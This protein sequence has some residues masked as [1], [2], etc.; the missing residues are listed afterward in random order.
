MNPISILAALAICGS[1]YYGYRS[2]KMQGA[3]DKTLFGKILAP[4]QDFINDFYSN[5]G[6]IID[7][8]YEDNILVNTMYKNLYGIKLEG[9][10]NTPVYFDELG[11]NE[12]F[13]TYQ[14]SDNAF[15]WYVIFKDNFYHRQ[16][17]FSYNKALLQSIGEKFSL[18]LL[19]GEKLANVILDLF[20]QNNFY[21]ENKDIHRTIELN[22]NSEYESN[23][24]VFSKLAR[25]NI[26]Q[27]LNRTD[28]YQSYKS[29][30]NIS[31]TNIQQLYK[32][33][34]S[35]AIWTYFDISRKSVE[36]YISKLINTAKWTGKKEI[37]T[38]LK[39]AYDTGAERFAIVNSTA[40]FKEIDESILGT[41]GTSLKVNFLK[42]DIFK[43]NTLQKTPLKFRDSEYDFL[44]PES[45]LANYISCVHK[46]RTAG[47]DFWGFDKNGGF[48]NY[49][50]AKDN[51]N[52]HS[53]IV[54][55]TGAGKS[56][57]LQKIITS[58]I[59]L[60][61]ET[62]KAE[63]L[64][65]DKVVVR[66][67]D[68]GFSNAKLIDFLKQNKDNSLIHVE[69]D[70]ANFSYN[71][72]N[73]DES[74][75]ETFEEDL[76][77]SADLASLILS[78]QAGAQPLTIDELSTYKEILRDIYTGKIERQRY[79]IIN[80]KDERL[81][82]R[83]LAAGYTPVTELLSL[84]DEYSYLKKPL[85]E[86]VIKRAELQSQNQQI[87]E[88]DRQIY[89]TL[90]RK[91]ESIE[92]LEYFSRFDTGDTAMADFISMDLN[93]YKESS[94]F[95]PIF[96]SVFQKTYIKDRA[97]AIKRKMEGKSVSKKLYILE[98]SPNYFRVPYFCILIDKLAFEARKYGVHLMI[99]AQLAEQLPSNILKV[100]DT[101]I[102]MTSP[103]KK[104]E[105]ISSLIKTLEPPE[106]VIKRLEETDKYEMCIWYSKG[107][108]NLKL[109]ISEAEDR[110]FNS[111][112]NRI[113]DKE[114]ENNG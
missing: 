113:I 93:N 108:F 105:L 114:V 62:H 21:I 67:Y 6:L 72:V 16:Y 11:V 10:S 55:N 94:L 82:N 33:N 50:F 73:L 107:V 24:R 27:N 52:P 103:D 5:K 12:L 59:N 87:Q 19:S 83:L 15:F 104:N 42:K 34:F 32:M 76:V 18:K 110:L 97:Y 41:F 51:D 89:N 60:N 56:Y 101:R 28:L 2:K 106:K 49:S 99:I 70:L 30:E 66:Y 98:E 13:R 14:N 31:K 77:F 8:I 57:T 88:N 68:I 78:S 109:Q 29:V 26:Y 69:S 37:F 65:R 90:R 9:T 111:D 85:L 22:F 64:G 3:I 96:V 54:A 38:E 112:P 46:A 20:L 74:S 17:L 58:M 25:E 4:A 92:K 100:A 95:V 39:N 48:T 91:L 102:L 44:V 1:A 23:Y 63:N 71:L 81:K 75:K 86:E 80:I 47:A 7:D 84:P 35:G 53:I 36:N 79:R 40:H 43:K 45:F 61:Y